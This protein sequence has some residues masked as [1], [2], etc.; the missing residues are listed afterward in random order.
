MNT[1]AYGNVNPIANIDPNGLM[2]G[3][4]FGRGFGSFPGEGFVGDLFNDEYQDE[5]RR[6][7]EFVSATGECITCNVKCAGQFLFGTEGPLYGEAFTQSAEKVI[8]EAVERKASDLAAQGT[9]FVL[10]RVF[11][12]LTIASGVDAI[13]CSAECF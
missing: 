2:F 3:S 5:I 12:P 4:G 8:N 7:N 10:K 11:V 9:K 13:Q 1:Y 6:F